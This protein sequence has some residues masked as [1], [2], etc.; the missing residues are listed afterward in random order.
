MQIDGRDEARAMIIE[1]VT[2]DLYAFPA[3]GPRTVLEARHSRIRLVPAQDPDGGNGRELTLLLAREAGHSSGPT[4]T[5]RLRL[6]CP[7]WL[8]LIFDVLCLCFG[9]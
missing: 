5:V 6:W 4:G 1:S 2:F 9:S 3:P 7:C 8:R